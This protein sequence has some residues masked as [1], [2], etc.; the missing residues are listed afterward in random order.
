M[1]TILGA[2]G[3]EYGPVTADK[4]REWIKSGRANAH[5]SIRRT[6]ETEWTTIAALPEFGPAPTPS[7]FPSAASA[8][9]VAPP[10]TPAAA[11][12]EPVA[13][14]APAA[15]GT[16]LPPEPIVFTGEWTEYFKIWIVNVLLT[17]VTLGIYAAWAK[18]RKQR[19]YYA[20]THLLG[21]TFEYLADPVRI[22]IGN[23]V[24]GA[25]FLIFTILGRI[26]PLI[27]LP[28]LLLF[29][30]ALPWF[31][32][33]TY[34][35][36]ARYT[37]WRGLRF[38]FRGD[39]WGALKVF[40]LWPMLVPFTLGLLLPYVARRQ[41]EFVVGNH[42]YGTTP[43]T[44]DGELSP[45]FKIYLK[46]VL[47]FLPVIIAYCGIIVLAVT[48]AVQHRGGHG[49]PPVA[50]MGVLGL[51]VIVG[52]P[53]AIAG[54]YYFRSRLFNYMWNSTALGSHRFVANMRAWDL[55]VLR[56]VNSLVTLATLG[57]LYPWAAL[58][59]VKFELDCL[60]VLPGSGM[61]EFV[62]ASQP[63]PVSAIGE[64]ATGF[65]DIDLGFGV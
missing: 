20:N 48:S 13:A 14:P 6:G 51:L 15:A 42:A 19:Y 29:L 36:N 11:A 17:I 44:F 60:Q 16:A 54:G 32:I 3:K 5:T 21:H 41:K 4:I 18:V 7:P 62:A 45:L 26:S 65:F 8:A 10:P 28:F 58:R 46:S 34:M 35:F 9:P 30:L 57:L 55:F 39:Y 23:L 63:P 64:A 37:A 12:P 52:L 2:D 50:A 59:L 33:R 40:V 24:V 1:F 22:L 49:S 27:Q 56:F 25:G 38:Q 43:F 47:F 61:D 53:F 31:I